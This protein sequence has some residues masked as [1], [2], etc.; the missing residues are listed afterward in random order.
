M[1]QPTRLQDRH[2][3]PMTTYTATEAKNLFGEVLEK[4]GTYGAV[5]I[6]KHDKP[7]FVVLSLDEYEASRPANR[8]ILDAFEA[9]YNEMFD[10]MQDSATARAAGT[11]FGRSGRT[12][13]KRG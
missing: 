12:R 6:T 5:A 8:E 1:S 7:R 3:Q 2:G 10:R 9:R 4:A 13:A 11:L